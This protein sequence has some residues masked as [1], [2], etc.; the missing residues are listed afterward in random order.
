MKTIFS[1]LISLLVSS[2]G[3][4]QDFETTAIDNKTYF[5]LEG[6]FD[7]EHNSIYLGSQEYRNLLFPDGWYVAFYYGSTSDLMFKGQII[8]GKEQGIWTHYYRGGNIRSIS[9][10]HHGV[11]HG[12]TIYYYMPAYEYRTE[13]PEKS[14]Y[15][16]LEEHLFRNGLEDS[17]MTMWNKQGSIIRQG[18]YVKGRREGNWRWLN[19]DGTLNREITYRSDYNIGKSTDWYSNGNKSWERFYKD[20][21][22]ELEISWLDSAR[23]YNGIPVGTWTGWHLNGQKRYKY[24]FEN[25]EIQ[26]YYYEWDTLG[27]L[28]SKRYYVFG[29]PVDSSYGIGD[30]QIC[31]NYVLHSLI[32][33]YSIALYANGRYKNISSSCFE[34]E[35]DS[36]EWKREGDI[37]L[38]RPSDS[39][40]FKPTYFVNDNKLLFSTDSGFRNQ[41]VYLERFKIQ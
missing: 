11:A 28:L 14:Y 41:G 29:F 18:N 8:S 10:Y 35:L 21:L 33:G 6:E 25:N 22:S 3:I 20:S 4:C 1:I 16:K 34:S 40:E 15:Y 31:G 36:G 9:N 19:A 23:I 2:L 32:G 30:C 7:S 37:I 27:D 26:G 17:T 5:I 39:S 12:K 38:L 13:H 24:S